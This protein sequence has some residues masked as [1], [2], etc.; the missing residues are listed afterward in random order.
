MIHETPYFV[1]EPVPT[2]HPVARV[3]F[4]MRLK[5]LSQ[6]DRGRLADR[7]GALADQIRAGDHLDTPR[8]ILSL[9]A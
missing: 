2:H 3:E 8:V 1:P 6:E 4:V 7:L 5:F 9:P